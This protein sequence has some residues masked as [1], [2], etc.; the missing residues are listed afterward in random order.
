MDTHEPTQE[1]L[2]ACE[3][4]GIQCEPSEIARLGRFLALLLDATSRINLTAI[5]D[6]EKAWMRHIF[7]ALTLLMVLG[8]LPEG[9]SIVDVGSGGGV[10][11]LPLAIVRP[12]W[13]V[14]CL[15]STGK[16]CDFL[17]QASES[18]GLSNVEVVQDRAEAAGQDPRYRE[19]FDG[20]VARAV[21][22]IRVL[23]EYTIPLARPEGLVVL[24]KG[25]KAQEEIEEAHQALYL[26]HADVSTTVPTPTG[27]LVVL[28]K[29]RKTPAKYPRA[30][31]EPARDPLA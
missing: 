16:K 30:V 12:D 4:V 23:A 17:R 19:R 9:S 18:L 31:G 20:V 11:A 1:F 29:T 6:P 10:P 13:S 28:Q 8:E 3:R 22:R 27:T 14:S 7:D 15:E 25:Q 24:T 5:R 26:L 21:G 2:D